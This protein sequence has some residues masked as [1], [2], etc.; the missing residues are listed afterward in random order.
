VPINVHG[1]NVASFPLCYGYKKYHKYCQETNIDDAFYNDEPLTIDDVG[2][3]ADATMVSN[4]ESIGDETQ[5]YRPDDDASDNNDEWPSNPFHT[6]GQ[7]RWTNP[8]LIWMEKQPRRW[9][10]SLQISSFDEEERQT[11]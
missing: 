5:K 10:W 1:N 3:Q 9:R 7:T 6:S 2:I 11:K 4:N 8:S